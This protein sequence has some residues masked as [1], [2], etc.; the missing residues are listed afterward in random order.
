[1][2]SLRPFDGG[3]GMSTVQISSEQLHQLADLVADRLADRMAGY[4][5]GHKAVDAPRLVDA[6]ALA[7]LLGVS[8]D[9]IYRHADELG[10]QRFADGPRGRLRFDPT[11]ALERWQAKPADPKLPID[12]KVS[13]Y[14]DNK[15]SSSIPLL[16]IRGER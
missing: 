2:R 7:D 3:T 11:V 6:Q 14:R 12:R 16:A 8:R 4:A 15:P 13:R 5:L 1:L 9:C 10:G